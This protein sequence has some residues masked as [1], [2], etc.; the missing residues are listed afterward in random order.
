M[1]FKNYINILNDISQN[2][3]LTNLSK[4]IDRLDFHFVNGGR[5]FLAGNGGSS[6]ISS[7][8]ATDLNKL[9]K[10]KKLINAISLNE[11]I[12]AITAFSN[13]DSYE[14]YLV[15]IIKNYKPNN[16]DTLIVVSSSGNSKNVINLTKFCKNKKMKTFALL[17]FNGGKL[18]RISEFP[19]LLESNNNYYG[20]IEDL[21]MMILHYIAHHFKNDLKEL[22]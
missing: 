8:A 17:G 1:S 11:N 20:P 7:H 9:E 13:D 15:N 19:I 3:N 4:L 2:S 14:N 18:Y 22:K 12:S 6:S 5:V 10:N 21:H 16:L